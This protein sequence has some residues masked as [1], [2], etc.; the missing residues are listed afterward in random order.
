MKLRKALILLV[1]CALSLTAFACGTDSGSSSSTP[2]PQPAVVEITLS[3]TDVTLIVGQE[4]TITATVSGT[5]EAPVWASSNEGIATV[6]GGKIT[7]ISEGTAQVSATI[8]EVSAVANVRVKNPV[9]MT[10]DKEE[11]TINP[12]DWTDSQG[13]VFGKTSEKITAALEVNGTAVEAEVTYKS[14]KTSVATV[15]ADGTV[16]AVGLGTTSIEATADY[17]GETYKTTVKVTVKK[18]DVDSIEAFTFGGDKN[19]WVIDVSRFGLKPDD[20]LG[21]FYKES[22]DDYV[23][24]DEYGDIVFDGNNAKVITDGIDV[25]E[26]TEADVI[27]LET[28]NLSITIR[29][30]YVNSKNITFVSE[31]SPMV[32]GASKQYKLYANG[33]EVSESAEWSVNKEYIATV[34]D[35]GTITAVNYGTAVITAK[36]YGYT[37][38]TTQ[39][40]LKEEAVPAANSVE[41]TVHNYST[42]ADLKGWRIDTHKDYFAGDWVSFT[43]TPAV[44]LT[45]QQLYVYY[46]LNNLEIDFDLNFPKGVAYAFM[47]CKEASANI[48]T[49]SSFIVLNGKGE[50]IGSI[51][52]KKGVGSYKAGETYTVYVQI[53]EDGSDDHDIFI[54]FSSERHL[55]ASQVMKGVLSW[56][57]NLDNL[58]PMIYPENAKAFVLSGE[59]KKDTV[60]LDKTLTFNASE[61]ATKNTV[62]LA[63]LG[64][65]GEVVAVNVEGLPRNRNYFAKNENGIPVVEN[66][67]LKLL[68]D[69]Y[70]QAGTK[71]VKTFEIDLDEKRYVLN[72]EIVPIYE[73]CSNGEVLLNRKVDKIFVS[74]KDMVDSINAGKKY[75]VFDFYASE[76]SD[77]AYLYLQVGARHIHLKANQALIYSTW[78][79]SRQDKL[80]ADFVKVFDEDGSL[81]TD[82]LTWGGSK[83]YGSA[84]NSMQAGKWYKVFLD[85]DGRAWD[86]DTC[87]NPQYASVSGVMAKAMGMDAYVA[88]VT[89]CAPA[90]LSG[91]TINKSEITIADDGEEALIVTLSSV[92]QGA[93]VTY[94]SSNEEVATISDDGVVTAHKA[95][96]AVITASAMGKEATC[97]VTVVAN[98]A[99]QE[100]GRVKLTTGMASWLPG[101]FDKGAAGSNTNVNP[102][103]IPGE[104]FG[105]LNMLEFNVTFKA[106]APAGYL[107]VYEYLGR[108]S[109]AWMPST[110]RSAVIGKDAYEAGK[111]DGNISPVAA[112][113]DLR[114]YDVTDGNKDYRES[115]IEWK[116][117]HT[118]KILVALHGDNSVG[119]WY[120]T[121][122][123][124]TAGN[125]TNGVYSYWNIP[126]YALDVLSVV[127]FGDIYGAY[128]A[129]GSSIELAAETPFVKVGETLQLSASLSGIADKTVTYASSNKDVATVSDTGLVSGVAT[130]TAVITAT[131]AEGKTASI[132]ITVKTASDEVELV[133]NIAGK[134]FKKETVKNGGVASAPVAPAFAGYNFAGWYN[135][136]T[137]FDFAAPVTSDYVLTA[138][139]EMNGDSS[140]LCLDRFTAAP[141][142]YFLNDGNAVVAAHAAGTDYLTFK[143][144]AF[145]DINGTDD[146][147]YVQVGARHIGISNNNSWIMSCWD[148]ANLGAMPTDAVSI[149]DE[150]G[151]LVRD[152]LTWYESRGEVQSVSGGTVM[153]GSVDGVIEAGK[154]YTVVINMNC[155]AWDDAFMNME[156]DAPGGI[157]AGLASAGVFAQSVGGY[158]TVEYV[159]L[160]ETK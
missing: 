90:E 131:N 49:D 156:F 1:I 18:V 2:D 28:E 4:E 157:V 60:T 53:P 31:N 146:F 120:T 64:I 119:F 152:K 102:A 40:V 101:T 73:A 52:G 96:V 92:M 5:D 144:T 158:Y 125:Y 34:S 74:A 37:Y 24:V 80:T 118:Y 143:F 48:F 33:I 94:K 23:Q 67:K 115:Y 149:Y 9:T 82:T 55:E 112:F 123:L 85:M 135:G 10:V 83:M 42:G 3:K 132:E 6:S 30:A 70:T 29:I 145:T 124:H 114:I 142:V 128:V 148:G 104:D 58:D 79:K 97:T 99:E 62:D 13:T 54:K 78:D 81:V 108:D 16:T 140:L 153:S 88:N 39:T 127:E 107:H 20:V 86:D 154:T 155:R 32:I 113:N 17:D 111:K 130:G 65:S 11:I 14:L 93:K 89:V 117:G 66:G 47:G 68:N 150:D 98:L 71:G 57:D 22:G 122:V 151:N 121:S 138:K 137:A 8:G 76:I 109:N 63:E 110:V 51:A 106:D 46:G 45:G 19:E 75:L 141:A 84:E 87:L 50:Q 26:K 25:E 129:G 91:I 105:S 59:T 21:I 147:L 159:G 44:D 77:S 160:S 100:G 27:V 7:A 95:G 136:E 35:D 61:L 133:Y 103:Y 56:R 41:V 12:V 15:A 43:F 139:Y 69:F 36:V 116:A 72:I 134:Q 38:T 126:G